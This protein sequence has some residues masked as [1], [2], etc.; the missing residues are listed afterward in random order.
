M[1]T[2]AK[3]V[4]EAIETVV[5]QLRPRLT[6]MLT[7]SATTEGFGE[8]SAKIEVRRGQAVLADV[9]ARDVFK[10]GT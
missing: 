5:R 10:L 6:A 2:T 7:R 4:D 1:S 3:Q 9:N 8:V